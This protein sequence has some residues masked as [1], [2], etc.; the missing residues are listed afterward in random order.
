M[1]EKMA[2]AILGRPG[3]GKGTQ[4]ELLA[5]H[6]KFFHF[7]TTNFLK[8][9]FSK[10]PEDPR[11]KRGEEQ[12]RTGVLVDPPFVFEIVSEAVKRLVETEGGIVFDGSP[13]TLYEA[14]KFLPFMVGLFG[15]NKVKF[16]EIRVS[17]QEIKNRLIKRL[18][19]EDQGHSYISGVGNLRVGDSCPE[20][21]SKLMPRDIDKPEI[22]QKRFK[23][24][25]QETVPALEYLRKEHG[26]VEINGEQPIDKVF[27]DIISYF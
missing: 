5:E 9:F 10:R 16:F 14:E 23:A 1:I 25:E 26:V 17:P 4:A 27:K 2:I 15:K 20:D 22:A 19:C 21:G 12:Y 18:V 13:R 8:D 11:V 7:Q 6:F 24:Y 3:S